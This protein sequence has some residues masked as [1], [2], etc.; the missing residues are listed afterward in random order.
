MHSL[1][2]ISLVVHE[3][4]IQ[5]ADVVDQESLV[6]RRHHVASL[7]VATVSDLSPRLSSV[8]LSSSPHVYAFPM[9]FRI[10]PPSQKSTH[11]G[12]S[13]LTLEASADTVV[14]SLWLSP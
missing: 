10:I 5:V 4:E 1:G 7:P 2:R 6:T 12:H 3:E 13:G 9:S 14:D 11:L 8:W